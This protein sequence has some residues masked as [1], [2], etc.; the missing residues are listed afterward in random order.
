LINALPGNSF[1][2]TNKGNN[3][4]ETVFSVRSAEKKHGAMGSLFP[5]NAAVNMHPQKWEMVFSVGTVQ[6][7]LNIYNLIDEQRYEFSSEFSV[8][9]SH[10]RFVVEDKKTS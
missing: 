6:R 7:S 5:G 8:E 9:E 4:T 10:G 2:N 1:V 3:R